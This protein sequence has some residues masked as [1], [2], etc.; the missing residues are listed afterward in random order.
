M[1]AKKNLPLEKKSNDSKKHV[2]NSVACV[3][4]PQGNL[5]PPPPHGNGGGGKRPA[6][7]PSAVDSK[8]SILK[9]TKSI[10][11]KPSL[12]PDKG[13]L[14]ASESKSKKD[15][16]GAD[17]SKKKVIAK[18]TA[19]P[20][21]P[22]QP[23]PKG[24]VT[25]QP[26]PTNRAPPSSLKASKRS[27]EDSTDERS[28]KLSC[29][30]IKGKKAARPP[31]PHA[32][33]G[34]K[35]TPAISASEP[36]NKS[37]GHSSAAQHRPASAHSPCKA[38]SQT[39][40]KSQNTLSDINRGTVSNSFSTNE[41]A[42]EIKKQSPSLN[43]K[44]T[45]YTVAS[46]R[47]STNTPA[48][49]VIQSSENN[50]G[51]HCMPSSSPNEFYSVA[52][53]LSNGTYGVW[54]PHDA[55]CLQ[56]LTSPYPQNG[57]C[58]GGLSCGAEVVDSPRYLQ[59]EES[60]ILYV[61]PAGHA[62]VFCLEAHPRTTLH[63]SLCTHSPKND[64]PLPEPA[65]STQPQPPMTS[66]IDQGE[67]TAPRA[68]HLASPPEVSE[69][70]IRWLLIP[71][72]LQHK[73]KLLPWAHRW[74]CSLSEAA[75]DVAHPLSCRKQNN[76]AASM[77]S[78]P[79]KT[80]DAAASAEGVSKMQHITT[81]LHEDRWW[82]LAKLPRGSPP[83]R[84]YQV[85]SFGMRVVLDHGNGKGMILTSGFGMPPSGSTRAVKP[86]P[87][88]KAAAT[89][90]APPPAPG[91]DKT[92]KKKSPHNEPSHPRAAATPQSKPLWETR[93]FIPYVCAARLPS[94]PCCE[95]G[96]PN[97]DI[98]QPPPPFLE[99]NKAT[100]RTT[101]PSK[102]PQRDSTCPPG[103]VTGKGKEKVKGDAKGKGEEERLETDRAKGP[104]TLWSQEAPCARFTLANILERYPGDL[105][106]CHP[107]EENE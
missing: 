29:L 71:T 55:S 21:R 79:V 85:F 27:R 100:S 81:E 43:V 10:T 75:W 16:G 28:G 82:D 23:P 4:K 83:P 30:E 6:V 80:E 17:K 19:P 94:L 45:H 2:S 5:K 24:P 61:N 96:N 37:S 91:K 62:M 58:P 93:W 63:D 32:K 67:T 15:Y 3:K 54:F 70:G 52:F 26:T 104:S 86:N 97:N 78:D 59:Q 99:A 18:E 56:I 7:P 48:A 102:C 57:G 46:W 12:K 8:Q 98:P 25:K 95:R 50:S 40:V 1:T 47:I 74:R 53:S 106:Y 41:V 68:L 64:G 14:L 66:Q 22:H 77:M 84:N 38:K 101:P 13:K 76:P 31:S 107:R 69:H 39:T 44:V 65:L 34:L 103:D 9:E 49:E 20:S 88:V 73:F 90:S 105:F 35:K 51:G 60:C 87:N 36:C 72:S 11:P 42:K 33:S 92:S 89:T